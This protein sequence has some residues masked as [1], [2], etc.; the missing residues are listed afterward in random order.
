M[1]KTS[2]LKTMY[3]LFIQIDRER[4][5]VLTLRSHWRRFKDYNSVV[6]SPGNMGG[7]LRIKRKAFPLFLS[8]TIMMQLLMNGLVLRGAVRY[9]ASEVAN[10]NRSVDHLKQV[11]GQEQQCR[12]PFTTPQSSKIQANPAVN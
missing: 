8:V 7:E 11:T 12:W 4:I 5:H 1:M 3:I 2:G 6:S 10:A 9:T